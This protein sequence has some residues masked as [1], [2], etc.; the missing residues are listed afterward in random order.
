MVDVLFLG[1]GAS[2]PSRD[3]SLPCI[4]VK[5]KRDIILFDCGEGSQR[6]LMVSPFS[7]MKIKAIFI[8]HMH[9]DHFLGLPGLL[10]TM[11]MSGR[12]DDI[13]LAGPKGFGDSLR[14]VIKACGG[15]IAYGLDIVDA[16]DG[17]TF[18]FKEFM[19]RAF[20]VSHNIPSLGFMFEENERIGKFNRSRA[21][22]M[23][24]IPGP[25]FTR[26][27]KGETVKGVRPG[28][29]IGPPRRGRRI[30]YSGDTAQCGRISEMARGA[31]VL[32]HEATYSSKDADLALEH[33]HSTS[34][35]AASAARDANVSVLFVTHMSN[36]YDDLSLIENECR[37]IF[38]NTVVARDLMLF[39][40]R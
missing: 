5:L 7:F 34:V 4:A 18:V 8:S 3:R 28:D 40:V 33:K 30:V 15:D 12:K 25:D 35:D 9:G 23:G 19:V 21:E 24:L 37:E 2:V 6:Q 32:I 29:V 11:S 31:E 17:D 10:Q 20:S 27:Q 38:P 1:T 26:L 14:S 16:S 36:R 13:I 22:S 39:S